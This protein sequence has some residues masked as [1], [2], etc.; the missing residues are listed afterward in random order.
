MEIWDFNGV[1]GGNSSVGNTCLSSSGSVLG[2][3]LSHGGK[4]FSWCFLLSGK[5][6]HI[7]MHMLETFKLSNG[8]TFKK[9][10]G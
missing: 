8:V 6:A 4:A 2:G 1:N 7:H 5:V 3:C 9:N 10:V